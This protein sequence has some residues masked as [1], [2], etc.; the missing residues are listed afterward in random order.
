M[1]YEK[2]MTLLYE[3]V[4][5][6]ACDYT[7]FVSFMFCFSTSIFFKMYN[8]YEMK[9]VMD[10]LKFQRWI[11]KNLKFLLQ[12]SQRYDKLDNKTIKQRLSHASRVDKQNQTGATHNKED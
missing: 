6:N 8:K 5:M 4:F 3:T 2:H 7:R 10:F 9:S 12:L 1:N 11:F